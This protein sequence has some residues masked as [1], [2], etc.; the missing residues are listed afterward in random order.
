MSIHD[1]ARIAAKS[2]GVILVRFQE[3]FYL[4]NAKD[5]EQLGHPDYIHEPWT[6]R[7]VLEY[8]AMFQEGLETGVFVIG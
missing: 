3:G 4:F 5:G 7:E 6:A 1:Q 2:I 8:C